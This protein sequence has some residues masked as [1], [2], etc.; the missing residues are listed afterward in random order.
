MFKVIRSVLTCVEES[1][2]KCHVWWNLWISRKLW[3]KQP[4]MVTMSVTSLLEG[5][6][7]N[8]IQQNTLEQQHLFGSTTIEKSDCKCS[9]ETVDAYPGLDEKK[10]AGDHETKV[11]FQFLGSSSVKFAIFCGFEMRVTSKWFLIF[12]LFSLSNRSGIPEVICRWLV[13]SCNVDSPAQWI[14]TRFF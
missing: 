7:Q 1:F 10:H 3:E 6:N 12:N 8:I 9:S 2:F 13:H 5:S 4:Y 11:M 14:G